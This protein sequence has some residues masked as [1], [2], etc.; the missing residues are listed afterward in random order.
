[1]TPKNQSVR[2][3]SRVLPLLADR[4]GE[5]GSEAHAAL[6]EAG[7]LT[8]EK[9]PVLD[10]DIAGL[11][12]V[13]ARGPEG[14]L[15]PRREAV[16]RAAERTGATVLLK[17]PVTLIA[18]ATGHMAELHLTGAAA[19]PWLATAGAGDVLAGLIAGLLARGFSPLQAAET[20]AW[21]HAAAG[22]RAGPGLIA[23]DLPDALPTV[24]RDLGL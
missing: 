16:H 17:G 22:R 1:M 8:G 11:A 2:L 10:G 21:L 12:V 5:V 3:P 23:E 7:R 15:A 9:W 4:F 6:R 13:L 24:F 20:G 14:D 19:V 18:D